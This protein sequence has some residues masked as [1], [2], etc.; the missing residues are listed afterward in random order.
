MAGHGAR[1]REARGV[2]AALRPR[3]DS[4]GLKDDRLT[5]RLAADGKWREARGKKRKNARGMGLG[6][7]EK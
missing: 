3:A 4:R 7:S 1:G 6:V 2:M 5:G